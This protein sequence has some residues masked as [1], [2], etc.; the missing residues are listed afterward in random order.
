MIE[1]IS[2]FR[3]SFRENVKYTIV[4]EIHHST[5]FKLAKEVDLL[6]DSFENRVP[7][8]NQDSNLNIFALSIFYHI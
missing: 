2:H 3:R 4:V 8:R 1:I 5:L 6:S 7:D